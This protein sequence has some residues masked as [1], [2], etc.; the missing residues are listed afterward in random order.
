MLILNI[1]NT[2]VST[3]Y[4]PIETFFVTAGAGQFNASLVDPFMAQMKGL[5]PYGALVYTFGL[6]GNPELTIEV[7]PVNC[8]T[9]QC[10]S[11]LFPGGLETI[12]PWAPTDHP[13]A[14]IVQVYNSPAAQMQF[15]KGI[16]EQEEFQDADCTVYGNNDYVIGV[17]FCFAPSQ[18]L[19][20]SYIAGKPL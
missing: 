3:V 9:A 8:T 20:G 13:E 6:V 19:P 5:V 16:A 14:P 15:Q 11:Y 1:V 12:T 18:V 4:E 17:K 10:E 2:S 7:D